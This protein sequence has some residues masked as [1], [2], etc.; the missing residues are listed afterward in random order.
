VVG[1]G[2]SAMESAIQLRDMAK[3][4]YII[5]INKELSGEEIIKDKID[6]AESI[7]VIPEATTTEILGDKFV[8][9]LKY[10]KQGKEEQ[11]DVQGVFIEIG[12]TPASGIVPF[13]DRNRQSEIIINCGVETNIPGLFAAGDVTTVPYKQ[14]IIAA[15]EG[16][17]AALAAFDYVARNS[18]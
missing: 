17:K 3:K 14:I 5:N 1:G 16:C 11:I 8:S 7:E 13:V 2:N 9:A 6:A 12:Y 18:E 10:E 4:V 15:G